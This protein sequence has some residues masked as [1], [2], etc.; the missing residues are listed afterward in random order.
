[1][2]RKSN[3]KRRRAILVITKPI[4]VNT[5]PILV[6][7]KPLVVHKKTRPYGLVWPSFFV[8]QLWPPNKMN[9]SLRVCT[10]SY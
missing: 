1:M 3:Q 5:K 8:N 10:D 6:T 2:I 7:T 4:L 9:L